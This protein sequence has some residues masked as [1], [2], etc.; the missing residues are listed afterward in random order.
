MFSE[1]TKQKLRNIFAVMLPIYVTQ[2]TVMGMNFF[3]TV[4]SGHAGAEDL[5][6]VAI[7]ANIW[8]PIFTGLNGILIAVTPIVAHH[9]GAERR[10][11]ISKTVVHGIYLAMGLGLAV[12]I[13]GM[14][15]LQ[16]ILQL[17][18]LE[19]KVHQIATGY[20]AAVA[21]GII[22]FFISTILRSV[23]DTLGYTQLTMRIF[24]L[25]LPLNVT[26]NYMMIFGK[27]GFPR[28]GGVGAGYATALTSWTI[29]LVFVGIIYK[30]PIL[31]AYHIFRAWRKLQWSYA[32][33][34]LKLGIPVGISIFF[35]TSVFGVVALFMAKF[36]TIAIAAHQAAINFSSTLYMLPLSFSMAL[37]IVVGVEVGAKRYK[38]AAEYGRLGILT[39][40][41]LAG[42]FVMI[43]IVGRKYVALLY[44]QDAQIIE[45]ASKFLFYAAFFQLL[46]AVATPIQGILRGYKEVKAAFYASLFA[47]WGVCLPV[48]YILDIYMGN[49][50]FSYWQSLIAGI[51]CSGCFLLVRMRSTQKQFAAR[52]G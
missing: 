40:L 8:M 6:G 29:C 5:A 3:D 24:L 26:F 31:R 19:P 2:L 20:L 33:E 52:E 43:V 15:F 11:E 34:I 10:E 48:G 9:I 4:M 36:G 30:L 25:T 14:L 50:P 1:S 46:D 45:L 32:K 35:E 47:Y 13:G 38:D 23:V 42:F 27:M 39:N 44:S 12:I 49:G 51:F 21:I 41:L 18:A 22:P 16:D 37:T 7:G 28:M 17:M